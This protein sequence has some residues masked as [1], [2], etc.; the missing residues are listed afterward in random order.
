MHWSGLLDKRSACFW[1][2]SFVNGVSSLPLLWST[3]TSSLSSSYKALKSMSGWPRTSCQDKHKN[4][5]PIQWENVLESVRGVSHFLCLVVDVEHRTQRPTFPR[6]GPQPF[7]H[8]GLLSWKTIFSQGWVGGVIQ[9]RYTDCVLYFYYYYISPTSAHQAVDAIA[10]GPCSVGFPVKTWCV[11][12]QACKRNYDCTRACLVASRCP[13]RAG[14]LGLFYML[15][16]FQCM[17]KVRAS[18]MIG[19]CSTFTQDNWSR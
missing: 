1:H 14:R 11:L 10:G 8:R 7:R 13:L 17:P 12:Y 2:H 9:L 5:D 18:F 19:N 4:R 6:R 3:Q 16:C 15:L